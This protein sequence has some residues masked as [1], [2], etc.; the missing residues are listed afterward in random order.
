MSHRSFRDND[1]REWEAWEVLPTA[2]ERRIAKS[3]GW[4]ATVERRQAGESRVL[5]PDHLQHGWL[6]FQCG[7]ERRRLAPIPRD[8]TELPTED[9]KELLERA[10]RRLRSRRR[11]PAS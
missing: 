10:E 3:S 8:W 2:V 9:L 1:G 4:T 11:P 7:A 6:A 5:V